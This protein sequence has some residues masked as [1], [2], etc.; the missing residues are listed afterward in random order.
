MKKTHLHRSRLLAAA[1]VAAIGA[2]AFTPSTFAQQRIGGDGR[3]MDA[4][5]RVGSGGFNDNS[6]SALPPGVFGNAIVTGDVTGGRGFQGNVPYFAPGAFHANLPGQF[7]DNFVSG[8]TN[9]QT[10]GTIVDNAQNV[11]LFVGD[12][13]GINPPSGFISTGAQPGYIPSGP[14]SDGQF[15]SNTALG[16]PES[17]SLSTYVPSAIFQTGGTQAGGG[18]SVYKSASPLFGVTTLQTAQQTNGTSAFNDAASGSNA[19]NSAIGTGDRVDISADLKSPALSDNAAISADQIGTGGNGVGLNGLGTPAGISSFATPNAGDG[20]GLNTNQ[21]G[22][23]AGPGRTGTVVSATPGTPGYNARAGANGRLN[24]QIG[25]GLNGSAAAGQAGLGQG[26]A[27]NGQISGAVPSGY[28]LNSSIGGTALSGSINT[29]EDSSTNVYSPTSNLPGSA[30][31]RMLLRLKTINPNTPLTPEQ[32]MLLTQAKMQDIKTA[33]AG[34][35]PKEGL[36]AASSNNQ[37]PM[38]SSGVGALPPGAAQNGPVIPQ[39]VHSAESDKPVQLHTFSGDASPASRQLLS[40]AEDLMKQGKFTSALEEYDLVEQ[41]FPSNPYIQLGRA[42]AELGASYYGLAE[43]HLRQ[44]FMSDQALLSAQLDLRSLLGA[45]KLQY[46]V[47]DLKQ[48]AQADPNESRPVFLLA[49]I[50]YNTNNP[51]GAAAYL[52]LAEKREGKPD[53]FFKLLRQ[54]WD[55]PSITDEKNDTD[56]NK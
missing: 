1:V 14:I 20:N 34:N 10:N 49:Y 8:S 36:P 50:C 54:H 18:A 33:Q 6:S 27:I 31:Q 17:P 55:L 52:D 45:D 12:S 32:K 13:R 48:I 4:N 43:A 44:A 16:S 9:V 42:N 11:H 41:Q 5:N 29:G 40:K 3:L 53:P 38:G 24:G 23:P 56:L 15:A 51:R 39:Q 22:Q 46:L 2:V 21:S 47:K 7:V 25:N 30:Y 28:A 26:N 37:R 35:A 19:L